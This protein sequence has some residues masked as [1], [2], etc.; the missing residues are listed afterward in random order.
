MKKAGTYTGTSGVSTKTCEARIANTN[1]AL[2]RTASVDSGTDKTMCY[3]KT[4][5][6]LADTTED[7]TGFPL[8]FVTAAEAVITTQ[9]SATTAAKWKSAMELN[10]AADETSV[11]GKIV[12][13][14]G[15]TGAVT[16]EVKAE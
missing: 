4:V 3:S 15:A 6:A 8:A 12:T 11:K 9:A 7:E 16:V 1:A 5:P 13:T 2:P 14:S 10:R